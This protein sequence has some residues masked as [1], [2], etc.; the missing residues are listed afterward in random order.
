MSSFGISQNF[1]NQSISKKTGRVNRNKEENLFEKAE[2]EASSLSSSSSSLP[3][4]SPSKSDVKNS[5]R[6]NHRLVSL[7]LQKGVI[8]SS[9]HF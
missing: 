2:N 8:K 3:S 5:H 4:S 1:L 6:G 7:K 9:D